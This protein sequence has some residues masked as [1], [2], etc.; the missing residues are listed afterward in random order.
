MWGEGSPVVR[1]AVVKKLIRDS[2][3]DVGLAVPK[4]P[5]ARVA[6]LIAWM[7]TELCATLVSLSAKIAARDAASMRNKER[8]VP[9]EVA[10]RHVLSACQSESRFH[11]MCSSMITELHVNQQDEQT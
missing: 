7:G 10:S 3:E 5:S 8:V 4:D 11:I 6:R 2:F 9:A 1:I